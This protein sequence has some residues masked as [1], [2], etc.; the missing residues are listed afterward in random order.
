MKRIIVV[1]VFLV[2]LFGGR[3]WG[4]DNWSWPVDTWSESLQ[5]VNGLKARLLVLPPLKGQGPFCRVYIELKNTGVRGQMGIRFNPDKLKLRVVDENNKELEKNTRVSFDGFVPGWE[6]TL[7]PTDSMIRMRIDA[8]GFGYS[9]KDKV[10]VT[11]GISN[12]W[13]IPQDT[14]KYYL[15]GS[16]TIEKQKSDKPNSDWSGTIEL[17]KTLIPQVH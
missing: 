6:T 13:S 7:L 10:V 4:A 11:A 2:V 8:D 5:S 12:I 3:S 14:H 9:P 16:L 15:T 17:P 1:I